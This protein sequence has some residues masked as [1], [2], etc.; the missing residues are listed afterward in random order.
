MLKR[1][2]KLSLLTAAGLAI[3]FHPLLCKQQR[4]HRS[5]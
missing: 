5:T 2:L 3:V 4:P 1:L